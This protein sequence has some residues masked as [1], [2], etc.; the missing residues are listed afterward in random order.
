[1]DDAILPRNVISLY[2]PM[3]LFGAIALVREQLNAN[4]YPDV[5]NFIIGDETLKAAGC[6]DFSGKIS[7]ITTKYKASSSLDSSKMSA[8]LNSYNVIPGN[9]F[10]MKFD[11]IIPQKTYQSNIIILADNGH[12]LGPYVLTQI[13]SVRFEISVT[14]TNPFFT[15]G[16]SGS[17]ELG[18]S[19]IKEIES[20]PKITA[21]ICECSS[22]TSDTLTCNPISGSPFTGTHKDVQDQISQLSDQK[23]KSYANNITMPQ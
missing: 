14:D 23:Y 22:P 19:G 8:L 11:N 20:N 16:H 2:L 18:F 9:N 13:E 3:R 15:F 6:G 1:M 5:K 12:D 17:V 7:E 4:K 10:N 21:I